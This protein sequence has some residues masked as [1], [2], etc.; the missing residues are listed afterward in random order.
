MTP[1]TQ[2]F[3]K[4]LHPASAAAIM[5]AL[6]GGTPLQTDRL[7]VDALPAVV[8]LATCG[9]RVYGQQIVDDYVA[10]LRR[11][12]HIIVTSDVTRTVQPD[13]AHAQCTPKCDNF[14]AVHQPDAGKRF[15]HI[16][17]HLVTQIILE[18]PR[19]PY[20]LDECPECRDLPHIYD[21]LVNSD[22]QALIGGITTDTAARKLPK[23]KRK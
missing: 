15:D 21:E 11:M 5:L 18:G 2:E 13:T 4:T 3:F 19:A 22:L 1:P 17:M 10:L 12:E 20:F 8:L 16:W 6:A 7:P 23:G 9:L 14:C